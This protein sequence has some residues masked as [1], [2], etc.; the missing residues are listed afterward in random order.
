M[1]IATKLVMIPEILYD[2]FCL[3]KANNVA[4]R[5]KFHGVAWRIYKLGEEGMINPLSFPLLHILHHR[6]LPR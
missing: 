4:S 1:F 3:R 5:R 6:P 2:P